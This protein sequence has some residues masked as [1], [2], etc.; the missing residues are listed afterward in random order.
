MTF[1][2]AAGVQFFGAFI[3]GVQS[4]FFND[5][6]TFSDG[7][8]QTISITNPS[9]MAGG[10]TFLGFTDAG[11]SIT[12]LTI[13]AGTATTGADF[14]GVDDVTYQATAVP[15]PA[16]SLLVGTGFVLGTTTTLRRRRSAR[17]RRRGC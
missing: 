10:V 4:T 2:F 12:S 14:I 8:S 1:S 7:T 11:R 15:E 17:M 13:N 9:A 5:T 6:L 3:T 16:S